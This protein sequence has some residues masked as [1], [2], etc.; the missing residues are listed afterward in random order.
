VT[1]YVNAVDGKLYA[2]VGA[3][4]IDQN[5]MTMEGL[6]YAL[7][8]NATYGAVT[9]TMRY[10]MFL[11]AGS[12]T[13][14]GIISF[15]SPAGSELLDNEGFE[16]GDFTSWTEAGAGT[17]S[18]GGATPTPHG[19][20]YQA[21]LAVTSAQTA[22]HTLTADAVAVTGATV[23]KFSSWVWFDGGAAWTDSSAEEIIELK[24]YDEAAGGGSLSRTDTIVIDPAEDAWKEFGGQYTSPSDA[25]SVVVVI[26]LKRT[27]WAGTPTAYAAI[28]DVS[29]SALS[30]G[31]S[32]SFEP[33]VS[34]NGSGL[35]LPEL[36]T[37]P[38]T[39]KADSIEVYAVPGL[40][41]AKDDAGAVWDLHPYHVGDTITVAGT[42][43]ETTIYSHT[44]PAGALG[45]TGMFN[46]H[47]F[48]LFTANTSNSRAV[49]LRLKVG[50]T[51]IAT[52]V[53]SF[54][55]GGTTTNPFIVKAEYNCANTTKTNLTAITRLTR[56]LR[57]AEGA[58]GAGGPETEQLYWDQESIDTDT[59]LTV[60]ITAQLSHDTSA[61]Y[62]H[63]RAKL[64]GPYKIT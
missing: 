2:A 58:G 25:L 21:K 19:G 8:H 15:E 62:W 28:D 61:S 51:T 30:V 45:T 27:N 43:D 23:Y 31:K 6:L 40:L 38:S 63:I 39:P 33:E 17:W 29:L 4:A 54:A 50:G 44:L 35:V 14:A 52:A 13:P 46:I 41:L 3:L 22:A 26:T 60:A 9:R 42:T 10:G 49:T 1:Y 57:L 37:A 64:D 18:V 34:I 56:T 53:L 5:A 16:D 48:A 47:T 7:I 20:S 11:P 59:A 24:W 12:T 55:V 32:I 36:A